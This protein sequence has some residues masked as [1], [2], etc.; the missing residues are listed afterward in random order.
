MSSLGKLFG[1]KGKGSKGVA[2]SPQEAIQKLRETEGILVKKQEFLEQ[3]IQQELQ[4][5][6][7]H[8][9]KN[10]R[11]TEQACDELLAELE[12]MEQEDLEKDLLN[13]GD[14]NVADLP[15]VPG[16]KLPSAREAKAAEEDEDLRQLESWIS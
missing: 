1:F 6:R 10:K 16:T 15:S 9:T 5:A 2:A 7:K 8:G 3:K 11:G 4:S 12:E 13:V 14:E